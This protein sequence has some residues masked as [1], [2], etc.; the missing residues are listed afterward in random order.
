M[1][2]EKPIWFGFARISKAQLS[3]EQGSELVLFVRFYGA[4]LHGGIA[5][6]AHRGAANVCA[7]VRHL[8]QAS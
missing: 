8:A 2:V 4:Y 7:A 6:V 1:L 5:G 3:L